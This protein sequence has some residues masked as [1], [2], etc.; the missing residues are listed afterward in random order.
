MDEESAGTAVPAWVLALGGVVLVAAIAI[1]ATASDRPGLGWTAVEVTAGALVD[2]ALAFLVAGLL[3]ERLRAWFTLRLTAREGWLLFER[4]AVNLNDDLADLA[5]RMLLHYAPDGRHKQNVLRETQQKTRGLS[6]IH[7][8]VGLDQVARIV[9]AVAESYSNSLKNAAGKTRPEG[10]AGNVVASFEHT[11][12]DSVALRPLADSI[13]R[14]VRHMATLWIPDR[15]LLLTENLSLQASCR[16]W[17]RLASGTVP[18]SFV[19]EQ[20]ALLDQRRDLAR[21]AKRVV[22]H[23]RDLYLAVMVASD[24]IKERGV[25]PGSETAQLIELHKEVDA[26]GKATPSSGN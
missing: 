15:F 16:E 17:D 8:A 5:V 12:L 1:A 13:D 18:S 2:V 25:E 19:D 20:L 7:G 10:W 21:A 26:L 23:A 9:T 4:E 3:I 11:P 22:E 24:T 6:T 14:S